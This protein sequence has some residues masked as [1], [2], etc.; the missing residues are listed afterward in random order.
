MSI[1]GYYHSKKSR[2][3]L[4][5]GNHPHQNIKFCSKKNIGTMLLA[6]LIPAIAFVTIL[7]G[8]LLLASCQRAP[9]GQSSSSSSA[10][11]AAKKG[12]SSGIFVQ[13][14]NAAATT[15]GGSSGIFVQSNDAR[16]TPKAT[17]TTT[18]TGG[19]GFPQPFLLGSWCDA[20]GIAAGGGGGGVCDGTLLDLLFFCFG[21]LLSMKQT[22]LLDISMHSCWYCSFPQAIFSETMMNLTCSFPRTK[23]VVVEL[24]AVEVE[25]VVVAVV[26]V[27]D[28][29]DVSY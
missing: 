6:F 23:Q 25:E 29:G 22:L 10:A 27:E 7:V 21:F 17:T 9:Q 20:G 1:D 5:V 8:L 24:H 28:V 3:A 13:S 26:V 12:G 2:L 4:V 18:T 16:T 19:G 15:K 14:N 11:A